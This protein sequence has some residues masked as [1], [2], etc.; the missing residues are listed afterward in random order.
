MKP[1]RGWLAESDILSELLLE[2][3]SMSSKKPILLFCSLMKRWKEL[4]RWCR[5]RWRSGLRIA[6]TSTFS[7]INLST[8]WRTSL[9]GG[10]TSTWSRSKSRVWRSHWWGRRPSGR[11]QPPKLRL[12]PWWSTRWW[13]AAQTKASTFQSECTWKEL[14]WLPPTKTF[15]TDYRSNIGST[16]SF[17]TM[18][19]GG[20]SNRPKWL[21]TENHDL[22]CLKY[23]FW[24]ITI[25]LSHI[26]SS[27][28]TVVHITLS[29][30]QFLNCFFDIHQPRKEQLFFFQDR[31]DSNIQGLLFHR[32][33]SS[34]LAEDLVIFLEFLIF[35]PQRINHFRHGVKLIFPDTQQFL[36]IVTHI[37]YIINI[38]Q[39]IFILIMVYFTTA[40]SYITW[41]YLPF[42]PS[43]DF[44][45]SFDYDYSWAWFLLNIWYFFVTSSFY[46][47]VMFIK[48]FNLLYF[49]SYVSFKFYSRR[50]F[51]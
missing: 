27:I 8:I 31:F 6:F 12:R 50:A 7:I 22:S 36:L 16:L 13:T 47:H 39:M 14:P 25:H 9:L 38:N 15:T 30:F 37:L 10:S 35:L 5:W 1:S 48:S 20:I 28:S 21:S 26:F 4:Q 42:T 24:L 23:P 41:L 3:S 51:C 19:I 44:L 17:S 33:L 18:K 29:L 11:G 34:D 49:I 40:S 45:N 43:W 2:E 32:E 46:A